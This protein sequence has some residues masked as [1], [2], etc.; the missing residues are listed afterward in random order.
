MVRIAFLAVLCA[1]GV[2]A[3]EPAKD[4]AL[5]TKLFEEGRELS[6]VAN[7]A[8]ACDRFG[9]SYEIDPAPGTAV[10]YADCQE[11]LGH[12]ARAWQLFDEAAARSDREAN[13]VRAQYARDRASAL[14]PRL[15][16]LVVKIADTRLDQLTV[17]IGG[18]GV[19][20]AAELHDH[21]DPGDVEIVVAAPERRYATTAHA[22]AGATTAVDVPALGREA[23]GRRRSWVMAAYATGGAGVASLVISGVLGISAARYYNDAFTHGQCFYTPRGDECTPDGLATVAAAHSRAN[24]GT[25]FFIGGVALV[26][27]SVALWMFA[28]RGNAIEITPSV[29][30]GTAGVSVAGRF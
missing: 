3:A 9:R 6:K 11:H 19:K 8:E 1:A 13:A 5:A 2:A 10:N 4:R 25:G 14:M 17:T 27:T 29:S 22:A 26:G 21:A 24:I 23:Q 20:P 12:L 18:R 16:T 15:G 28:P 30:P 7:Y